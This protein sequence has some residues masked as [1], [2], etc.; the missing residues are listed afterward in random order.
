MS[1]A[2]Y[3]DITLAGELLPGLTTVHVPHRELGRTAVRQ[4][5][6][7]HEDGVS[8]H[9]TL[10][11]HI[12]VRDSVGAAS[13]LLGTEPSPAGST[14]TRGS[15]SS[16]TKPTPADLGTSEQHVPYLDALAVHS[17][18][19]GRLALAVVNDTSPTPCRY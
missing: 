13:P 6:H 18:D 5:L 8:Q 7:R 9:V 10:G 3:D 12:V 4:A 14:P 11:R 19:G 15:T 17:P 2:G 16:I 1:V